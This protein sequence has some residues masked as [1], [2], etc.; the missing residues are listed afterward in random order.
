MIAALG[1]T[2]DPKNILCKKTGVGIKATINQ[3]CPAKTDLEAIQLALWPG[4]TGTTN[5][6]GGTEQNAGAGLFFI[7]TIASVNRDFFVIYSGNSLYKLL[8]KPFELR[9]RLNADPFQDR[10][11]KEENLP[12]WQ[13]TVIGMDIT[14]D[15]TEEIS[16]LLDAI[17]ETYSVAVQERK[18]AR[19]KNPREVILDFEHVDAATQSFIHALISDILRK[20][21]NNALD[22]IAF[23]SCND[24]I[25]KIINIVVDYMQEGMGN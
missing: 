10:H 2:V 24:T 5:R 9:R 8:K 12:L 22:R 11:S 13:G 20:Y 1:F 17:R 4:I 18:R 14:L 15:Q 3:S 19:Y 7:K 21:G 6:E 23:K 25:K 16:L